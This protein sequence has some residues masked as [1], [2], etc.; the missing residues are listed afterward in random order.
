[1]KTP[2]YISKRRYTLIF[3]IVFLLSLIIHIGGS[4][5]LALLS[6]KAM[7]HAIQE[8]L[9]TPENEAQKAEEKKKKE[10]EKS[11]QWIVSQRKYGSESGFIWVEDDT[12][13]LPD[14]IP[15]QKTPPTASPSATPQEAPAQKAHPI[16]AQQAAQALQES[17]PSDQIPAPIPAQS[18]QEFE[19]AQESKQQSLQP[20]MI[21]QSGRKRTPEEIFQTLVQQK[22]EVQ[23]SSEKH[24][25]LKA[26]DQKSSGS[27]LTVQMLQ[28][29]LSAFTTQRQQY[30]TQPMMVVP[31]GNDSFTSTSVNVA[32]LPPEKQIKMDSYTR[33]V[34][35]MMLNIY[36]SKPETKPPLKVGVNKF[37][38]YFCLRLDKKGNIIGLEL[39][40]SCGYK[41]I[42]EK[43]LESVREAKNFGDLP[44]FYE[45]ETCTMYWRLIATYILNPEQHHQRF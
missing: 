45:P 7:K 18:D 16:S 26:R 25:P 8:M 5:E 31:H 22:V 39:Q 24:P 29:E 38:V 10:E 41:K 17:K 21:M 4:L 19:L 30:Q 36:N 12:I 43:L 27:G 37:E 35:W 20:T 28:K 13:M 9:Q 6:Y 14:S 3:I 32:E 42:D 23:T 15:A 33:R 2:T 44:H 40:K 1:M 34:A 11:D